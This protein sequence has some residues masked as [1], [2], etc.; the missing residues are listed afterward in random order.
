MFGNKKAIEN[1]LNEIKEIKYNHV[2]VIRK[3]RNAHEDEIRNLKNSH[4]DAIL[5]LSHE[6]ETKRVQESLETQTKAAQKAIDLQKELNSRIHAIEM[7]KTNFKAR[8]EEEFY[9]K[10][11]VAVEELHTKGNASSNFIQEIA[12]KMIDAKRDLI[13]I[14]NKVE[15]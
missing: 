14:E 15:Q 6:M 8:L 11:K 10:L 4:A 13:K 7:E 5:K 9:S 2:D 3:M 12:L 1:L